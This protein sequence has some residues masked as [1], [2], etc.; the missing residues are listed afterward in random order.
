MTS[1]SALD[2]GLR[3]VLLV[4]AVPRSGHAQMAAAL[5]QELELSGSFVV[6]EFHLLD[7]MPR[8]G[9]VLPISYSW[10]MRCMPTA[11]R[12]F[13]GNH[14]YG[15]LI[16]LVLSLARPF[17]FF[18]LLQ[19]IRAF[20]PDVIV[21]TH[22]FQAQV[23]GEARRLHLIDIPVWV[24]PTD[25]GAHVF[26]AHPEIERYVVACAEVKL[27]LE[28]AGIRA[29]RISVTGL[30]IKQE[31]LH[32]PTKLEVYERNVELDPHRQHILILGGSY[33]LFPF[34]ELLREIMRL[35]DAE[36]IQWLMVFGGNAEARAWAVK[37]IRRQSNILLFGFQ[38]LTPFLSVCDLAI[39][40]PGGSFTSEALAAGLPLIIH[41]PLPGQEERNAQFL[42]S[43]RA[44][45]YASTPRDAVQEAV[46]LLRHGRR[47]RELQES[48]RRIA[49][50][51]AGQEIV[52]LLKQH[53][54]TSI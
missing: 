7:W 45:I 10:V 28:Q 34:Q 23:L 20:R 39:A 46:A 2:E 26:W 3:R 48:V 13:H 9:R 1:R 4:Y 42:F 22:F 8:L 12:Y 17:G 44:A 52:T 25:Y 50:P 36:H 43:Q 49:R 11:W 47:Y 24:L 35:S 51:S 15:Y 6:E 41:R 30:P 31:I 18:G 5:R 14:R 37:S 40:K 21:A 54:A 32:L 29:Q 16:K 27:D 53:Y 38:P 33:G 19:R